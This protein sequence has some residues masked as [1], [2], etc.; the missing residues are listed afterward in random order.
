MKRFLANLVCAFVPSRNFRHKIRAN[1]LNNKYIDKPYSV[2]PCDKYGSDSSDKGSQNLTEDEHPTDKPYFID[3]CDKY[4][5]DKGSRKL[6]KGGH[7]YAW[8][9][10]TY[11]DIYDL[12]FYPIREQVRNIFECGIGTNN[13]DL[14]SS[15]GVNGKP[16]ASLRAWRD[17]FPNALVWGADID[18]DVLFAEDRIKT[19]FIDQTNPAII[20]EFF[21]HT[22]TQKFDIIVDDGY[23]CFAA[24]STLFQYAFPYLEN[25]GIY[26]IEDV[27]AVQDWDNG[28][29]QFFK[30]KYPWLRPNYIKMNQFDNNLIII[31]K[32]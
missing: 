7:P 22:G 25:G 31:R 4:G 15:M 10:H 18:R 14:R 29:A 30:T 3:L 27:V 32:E 8:A 24:G 11:A 21:K 16:G 1:I 28:Y 19:G 2:D 20:Q 26:V 9:P 12:L 5:S 23:H 17:Y 13:P 6:D